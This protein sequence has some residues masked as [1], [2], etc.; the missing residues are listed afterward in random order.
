MDCDLCKKFE[1]FTFS[2]LILITIYIIAPIETKKSN[3]MVGT[4]MAEVKISP[5][6]DSE[7]YIN[8]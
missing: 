3:T 5:Y 8:N 6:G 7:N 1:Q 2:L 4:E